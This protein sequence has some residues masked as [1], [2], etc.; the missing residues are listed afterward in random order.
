M[1]TNDYDNCRFIQELSKFIISVRN[2]S[3][4]CS[5]TNPEGK[6]KLNIEFRETV[7]RSNNRCIA[8]VK[9]LITGELQQCSCSAKKN[10][11]F[12]GHHNKKA[13][14]TIYTKQ[15]KKPGYVKQLYLK[16]GPLPSKIKKTDY[17]KTVYNGWNVIIDTVTQNIFYLMCEELIYLGNTKEPIEDI[18][19]PMLL[20]N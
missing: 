6:I 18:Y 2:D 5:T 7:S 16:L 9:N 10:Q 13:Q 19:N 1:P 11:Q 3:D 14:Q 12:C 15:P 8:L 4:L 20:C 17:V